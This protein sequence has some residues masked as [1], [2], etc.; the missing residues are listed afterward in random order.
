[1]D[2]KEGGI[3]NS[4]LKTASLCAQHSSGVREQITVISQRTH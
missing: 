3:Y 4:E 1:V 2:D